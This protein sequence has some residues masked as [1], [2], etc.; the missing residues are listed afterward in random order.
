MPLACVAL[1]GVLV[2]V[3][4]SRLKVTNLLATTLP[5]ECVWFALGMGLAVASVADDRRERPRRIVGFIRDQPLVCWIGAAACI[6]LAAVVLHPGGLFNIILSLRTK[7]PYA[8][9]VGGIALQGAACALLLA[10]AVFG[11][12]SGGLPRRLLS[13]APLAWVGL[14]SYGVYLY[15]LA[16]VELLGEQRDPAHFSATGLGLV[17]HIHTL[18]TP[19][20]LILSFAASAVVAAVSYY[21]IELRFLRRKERSVRSKPG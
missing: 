14:V 11:E 5:G 19:I 12:H 13:W 17:N 15:Q 8:R 18:T 6:G 3:A 9:T 21:A 20:L 7:Q 2:Q 4:A 10:P 16:I 1:G